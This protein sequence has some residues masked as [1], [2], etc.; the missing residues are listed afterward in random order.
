MRLYCA[1]NNTIYHSVLE[2]ARALNIDRSAIHRHLKGE[3]SMA[4]NYVFA[5]LDDISPEKVKVARAWL[6]YSA[7]NIILDCE[8]EPI[9]YKRGDEV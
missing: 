2:A 7:F 5:K 8:D 6:L 9:I 3:R 4:G 1:N